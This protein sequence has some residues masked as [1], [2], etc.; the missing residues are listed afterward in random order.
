VIDLDGFRVSHTKDAILFDGDEEEELEKFL[1]DFTKD[2]RDYAQK[3]RGPRTGYIWSKDKVRDLLQD[4]K[5]EF[6]SGEMKDAVDNSMLPP[7]DTILANNQNQVATLSEADKLASIDVT[8]DLRLIVSLQEKSEYEP[9]LTV[10]TGSDAG[11]IHVIINGL[12]PYYGSIESSDAI[13][14]CI[15]QYLYDAIAE[16]RVSKLQGRVNPDS[17][18]RLKDGLLRVQ[19]I[20]FENAAA[21]M[22]EG[23][24]EAT[25]TNDLRHQ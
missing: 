16:Y 5:K 6:G 4:M 25:V 10:A 14:E 22:R 18:R 8:P 12:H 15:R 13:D 9:H 11:V 21:S 3:R 24:M 1:A 7:I 2:Y 23:S 20:Q 17:V 19:A